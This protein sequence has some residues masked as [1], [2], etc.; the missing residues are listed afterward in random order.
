MSA[1]P[2]TRDAV[3]K[4]WGTT[5][6]RARRIARRSRNAA[7]DIA[8][9]LR[10]LLAELETTLG[11]GTQA[12]ATALRED[13]RKRLDVA[14]ER[15]DA[16]RAAAREQADVAFASADDY[17]RQNPWQAIAIVG[18]LAL[19]AGALIARYR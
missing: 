17:V 19:I 8:D 5:G 1:F 7:A 9:E 12:D 11:A 16:L 18:G 4:S 10:D 13:I 15:L 14:S 2:N 6:R 3:E